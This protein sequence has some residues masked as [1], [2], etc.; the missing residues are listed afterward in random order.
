MY[1]LETGKLKP[2]CHM[3][4]DSR[5]GTVSAQ[6]TC[7]Q[8]HFLVRRRDC[9]GMLTVRS[10]TVT[11]AGPVKDR[12]RR[13]TRPLPLYDV[14]RRVGAAIRWESLQSQLLPEVEASLA[15]QLTLESEIQSAAQCVLPNVERSNETRRLKTRR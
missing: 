10:F 9:E 12:Q 7:Q 5:K 11:T 1:P 14:R 6:R 3:T 8:W 4:A 13:V 15:F 2:L